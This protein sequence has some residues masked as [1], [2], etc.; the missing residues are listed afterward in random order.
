[1]KRFTIKFMLLLCGLVLGSGTVWADDQ[2]TTFA[3]R[4][5]TGTGN[6]ADND[7][8]TAFF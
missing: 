3:P 5:V 7:G 1:M 4:N 6:L 2:T 8:N